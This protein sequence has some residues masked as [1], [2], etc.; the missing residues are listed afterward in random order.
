MLKAISK[1]S[2]VIMDNATHHPKK[3]LINLARR[4]G[5][6][7]LFLP[8]YSPDYNPIEKDW[9]NMKKELVEIM[10]LPKIVTL[11][12]GIYCYF[13]VGYY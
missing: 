4:H 1:G 3:K 10:S 7:L 13:D 9:A 5:I 2:T 12:D 6:R 8:P 11:E